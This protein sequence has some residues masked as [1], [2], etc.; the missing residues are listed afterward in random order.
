M[1][2]SPSREDERSMT[3]SEDGTT[4]SGS[5]SMENVNPQETVA[6]VVAIDAPVADCY[7]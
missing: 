2:K 6:K 5:Y 4:T 7:V 3:V 1:K